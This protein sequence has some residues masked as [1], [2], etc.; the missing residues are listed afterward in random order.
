MVRTNV[1]SQSSFFLFSASTVVDLQCDLL[2][3]RFS[4][5][6]LIANIKFLLHCAYVS[7]CRPFKG[8]VV[9]YASAGHWLHFSCS[10]CLFLFIAGLEVGQK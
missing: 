8:F 1:D 5:P 9:K 2:M 4:L 3:L 7:A 10:F 6:P